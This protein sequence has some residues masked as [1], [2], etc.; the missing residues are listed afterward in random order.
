MATTTMGFPPVIKGI[1]FGFLIG[2][3]ISTAQASELPATVDLQ[4][5]SA[6]PVLRLYGKDAF[7][8]L[9]SENANGIAFG[10]VN[11]DGLDDMI[12]G[13]YAAD[14]ESASNP[15]KVELNNC[16]EVYVI[17]GRRTSMGQRLSLRKYKHL[18]LHHTHS[19]GD[20]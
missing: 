2:F 13:A 3:L 19:W 17:Y 8:Y 15:S 7:D 11:G 10:D 16:G 6:T 9:G 20:R 1:F 4:I 12:V 14:R 5:E 18:P